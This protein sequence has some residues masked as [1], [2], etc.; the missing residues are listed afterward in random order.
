MLSISF[1]SSATDVD[2]MIGT[3]TW[4]ELVMFLADWQ[5]YD[6]Q[7]TRKKSHPA[8]V[9][10]EI[11]GTRRNDNVVAVYGIAADIDTPPTDDRY[12]P[13]EEMRDWLTQEGWAFALYTTTK[14][15]IGHHRYRVVLMFEHAIAPDRHLAA[16]TAVNSKL[17]GVIDHGTKDPA[18]LSFLPANWTGDY[19]D[20]RT[21]N[22]VPFPNGFNA[23][24]SNDGAPVLTTFELEELR[25]VDPVARRIRQ[26]PSARSRA[27]H[28]NDA[29]PPAASPAEFQQRHRAVLTDW[30]RSPYIADWMRNIADEPGQREFRFMCAVARNAIRL[31]LW[32]DADL[33]ADIGKTFSQHGLGRFVP[34]DLTR[35]A[36]NALE[37][38]LAE[39]SQPEA[40][41]R[42]SDADSSTRNR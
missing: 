38:A 10:A 12:R 3:A 14:S 17:G 32:I 24:A 2:P 20:D 36:N 4:G 27:K 6:Q 34:H 7:R 11:I 33:L 30:K 9:L 35:Q 31:G 29:Y 18:R 37:F 23:F 42:R 21:G 41:P 8:L 15:A 28:P 16:W 39:P 26:L 1:F 13:F 22:F 19:R 25:S 40:G 5:N